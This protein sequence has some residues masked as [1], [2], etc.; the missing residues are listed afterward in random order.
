MICDAVVVTSSD[1]NKIT[2]L[3]LYGA[4]PRSW[5]CGEKP[6]DGGHQIE[7]QFNKKQYDLLVCSRKCEVKTINAYRHIQKFIPV[8]FIGILLGLL[9]NAQGNPLLA[10][11]GLFLMG[12]TLTVCPFTTPQTTQ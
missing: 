6:L 5:W 9:L 12:V 1:I 11:T 8:F 3:R 7:I 2:P 10:A 4:T